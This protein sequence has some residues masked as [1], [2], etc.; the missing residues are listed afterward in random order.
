MNSKLV[1]QKWFQ[2][3]IQK[4][5]IYIFSSSVEKNYKYIK[6]VIRNVCLHTAAAVLS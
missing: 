4:I 6:Q 1:I 5:Q 2:A 3:L